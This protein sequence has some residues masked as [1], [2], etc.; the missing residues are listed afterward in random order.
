M[1]DFYTNNLEEMFIDRVRRDG[2]GYKTSEFSDNDFPKYLILRV[3][4]ARALKCPKIPLKSPQWQD[5]QIMGDKNAKKG[6]YHLAQL[7]GKGK[8]KKEDFDMAFR[9]VLYMQHK[10][11]LDKDIFTDNNLYLDILGKYIK[12]GLFEL[13]NSWKNND[14]IYQWCLE[15]LGFESVDLTS[16][17]ND[18]KQENTKTD[19]FERLQKYFRKSAINIQL[20]N[21]SDSYRH[22]I[23]KVELED[24]DKISAFKTKAKY[25]DDEFGTSVLVESCEGIPRG[26]NIQIAKPQSQWQNL[27]LAEFKQ[28]LDS[29]KKQDCKLGV[30]AGSAVDKS[31]F[32]FDLA[33]TPHC[34]VAGTTGSGKTK[35]IQTMIVCLLQNPNVEVTVIDPKRGIDFRIFEPK[36]ELIADMQKAGDMIDNLIEEMNERN[37][38]MS[39]SGVNNIQALG[40]NFKVLII[41]ELNNLVENDKTIKDRLARL[42]EMARQAGIHLV[43]GTQRPDG[44]LLKGLRNNIDG[45]IALRVNKESES[46]IIL[47]ESGAEKLLGKGDMLIKVGSMPKPK[48][49]FS[50]LLQNDEIKSLI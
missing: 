28:G 9:A 39:Q 27:G 21:N 8:D 14:S 42:A 43:L 49:I 47:D 22:H 17:A 36:I 40:L 26:Y 13:H 12:R 34:F 11:E 6:E 37:A 31:A 4:F 23:C 3:A 15:N 29:L 18:T 24:S 32:C 35:F 25:L 16:N 38:Q 5:K 30:Y 50:C 44:T 41:D 33:T 48:H 19:Y 2:F 20:M 45:K 1:A 10:D 7:T 46:K